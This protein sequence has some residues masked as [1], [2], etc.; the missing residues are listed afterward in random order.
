[1]LVPNRSTSGKSGALLVSGFEAADLLG[2]SRRTMTNYVK[3]GVINPVHIKGS[4]PRLRRWDIEH[5]AV[6][7]PLGE[8]LQRPRPF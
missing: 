7:V 3:R 5:S 4:P 8:P 6:F 1:M 2:V